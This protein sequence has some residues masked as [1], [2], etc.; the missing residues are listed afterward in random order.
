[1]QHIRFATVLLLAVSAPVLAQTVQLQLLPGARYE[2][3]HRSNLRE[4]ING[5]HA[6]LVSTEL[7][8][9]LRASREGDQ[10]RYRGTFFVLEQTIRGAVNTG[11]RVNRS[12]EADFLADARGQMQT[13][14]DAPYPLYRN[15][16]IVPQD[17][18]AVGEEWSGFGAITVDPLRDGRYVVLP[19]LVRYRYAGRRE[20]G[21]ELGHVIVADY[22]IRFPS[23]AIYRSP[24]SNILEMRGRHEAEIVMSQDGTRPLFIRTEIAEQFQFT[25][26]DT[27]G[28]EGF[29][30][31]FYRIGE[32]LD[33]NRARDQ[34]A[35]TLQ[36]DGIEQVEVEEVAAGVRLRL[37][38]LQFVADQAVLLPG[39]N[40]RLDAIAAA[41]ATVPD[42]RIVVIGHA[43]SVGLDQEELEL[44]I[45]RAQT[46]VAELAARGI[47]QDRLL[48]EGRGSTEPIATN[49]T[50]EGRAQN[51]RVELV[52]VD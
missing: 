15:Y 41:L 2:V 52:V 45:A 21:D 14:V 25:S 20:Y 39:E 50:P 29:R 1:M 40:A 47:G 9:N 44:S 43:A 22:A 27:L 49:A 18:V 35:T 11:R 26:G 5:R 48:F 33:R 46:I 24:D 16:P 10:L 38:A 42:R 13:E 3:T 32:P 37:Q 7:T 19:I 23:S 17:A 28:R 31:T 36:R 34:I 8:G 30:L 51:R 6:G 12:I 4:S